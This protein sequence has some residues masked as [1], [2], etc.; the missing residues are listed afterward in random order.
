MTSRSEREVS[1]PP[2]ERT[3]TQLWHRSSFGKTRIGIRCPF[4]EAEVVAYV[5]SLAGGGKRCSC[6][7]MFSAYGNARK[8]R[9]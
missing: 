3:W 8:K 1:A 2:E 5:W 6:G 4:C 9:G 7:A